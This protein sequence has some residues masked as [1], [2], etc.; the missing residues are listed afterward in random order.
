M[1]EKDLAPLIF[2]G[3]LIFVVICCMVYL[4]GGRYG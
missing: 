4:I 1:K 3:G 2:M